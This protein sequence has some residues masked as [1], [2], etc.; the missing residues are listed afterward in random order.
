MKSVVQKRSGTTRA[1]RY[2]TYQGCDVDGGEP[3]H[4]VDRVY[5]SRK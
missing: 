5:W 4:L 2:K 1:I 3:I